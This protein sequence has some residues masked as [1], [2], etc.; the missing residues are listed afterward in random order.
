MMMWIMKSCG[1]SLLR[2]SKHRFSPDDRVF[3]LEGP[4]KEGKR[5]G[6]DKCR[7]CDIP[8]K[9]AFNH[10]D[11]CG[12]ACCKSCCYKLV[13][14]MKDKTRLGVSCDVCVAKISIY[15]SYKKFKKAEYKLDIQLETEECR[16]VSLVKQQ[17]DTDSEIENLNNTFPTS[18]NYDE[19]IISHQREIKSQAQRLE[20]FSKVSQQTQSLL[21]FYETELARVSEET[22]EKQCKIVE[23]DKEI[24]DLDSDHNEV[25][26][27]I[28]EA[29]DELGVYEQ[30]FI[31][32]LHENTSIMTD[33]LGITYKQR[34]QHSI[35]ISPLTNGLLKSSKMTSNSSSIPLNRSRKK[36]RA[37]QTSHS[38]CTNADGSSKCVTF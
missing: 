23:L 20:E 16:F 18:E 7:V 27:L 28:H 38:L 21:D 34:M 35:K 2:K 33:S 25:N 36:E 14:F 5:K 6:G 22:K 26:Y 32:K 24:N 3:Q 4:L 8:L 30:N 31:D 12:Y 37:N 15:K 11:F 10:C 29:K 1:Q 19:E 13:P 9:K 17:E